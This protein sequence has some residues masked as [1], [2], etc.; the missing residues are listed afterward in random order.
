MKKINF[1]KFKMFADIAHERT[2]EADVSRSIADL[3]YKMSNGVVSLDLAM[4]IYKSDGEIELNPEEYAVLERFIMD[5]TTAVFIDS[6]R[7]NVTEND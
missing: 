5:N 1:K 6:F 3:M 2:T 4:R 7:A